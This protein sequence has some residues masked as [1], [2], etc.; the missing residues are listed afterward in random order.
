MPERDIKPI[1]NE[2]FRRSTENTRRL[3]ALEERYSIIEDR[4]NSIQESLLRQTR[5]NKETLEAFET[6]VTNFETE[7][8]KINN[9]LMKLGKNLDRTARKSELKELENMMSLFNPLKST[10]ISKREVKR[11]IEEMR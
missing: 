4:L 2:M 7:L 8:M 10:F 3:R 9:S 1:I 6:I 11:L 5:K